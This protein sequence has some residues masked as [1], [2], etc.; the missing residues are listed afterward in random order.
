MGLFKT[1]SFLGG[2]KSKEGQKKKDGAPGVPVTE[3]VQEGEGTSGDYESESDG[4]DPLNLRTPSAGPSSAAPAAATRPQ[5]ARTS[6]AKVPSS[7]RETSPQGSLSARATSRRV[8]TTELEAW[9]DVGIALEAAN[10]LGT[11]AMQVKPACPSR[12][13]IPYPG[14]A[15]GPRGPRPQCSRMHPSHHSTSSPALKSLT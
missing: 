9:K 2:K 7:D 12:P 14:Y 4:A 5:S 6:S 15:Q 8:S 11:I 13:T 3:A 1:P 10:F